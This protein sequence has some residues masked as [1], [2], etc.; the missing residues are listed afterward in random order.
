MSIRHRFGSFSAKAIGCGVISLGIFCGLRAQAQESGFGSQSSPVPKFNLQVSKDDMLKDPGAP[1]IAAGNMAPGGFI[2]AAPNP[3]QAPPSAPTLPPA[4]RQALEQ[5]KLRA[6][7]ANNDKPNSYLEE[8]N[9]NWAPWIAAMA[10]T[11]YGNLRYHEKSYGIQFHTARP[12]LIQFTCYADGHIGNVVLR[13][14]SG[15][16]VYDE[17]QMAA[18]MQVAP[19]APFPK[20]TAKNSITLVQGW[21]SHRKRPGESD[22]EPSQ[23]AN[24]YQMERVSRWAGT[25]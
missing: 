11:W 1:A 19:L 23:F 7:Q 14:S 4:L 22:F 25:Q 9:V 6:M 20:G 16:P 18:L 13:Q 15:I 10:N 5:A 3:G 2:T 8:Y 12:A 24:R 21:E 17:L